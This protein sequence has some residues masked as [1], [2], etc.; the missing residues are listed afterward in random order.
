MVW[1]FLG[2]AL[3]GLAMLVAYAVWL[4]HLTA[5]VLSEV[6]VLADRAGQLGDLL[7]QIQ[8]PAPVDPSAPPPSGR[9]SAGPAESGG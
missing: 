4:A 5:D 6:G 2:V 9:R 8:A 7:G 3:V 1:V